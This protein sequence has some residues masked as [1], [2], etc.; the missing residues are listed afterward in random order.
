MRKCPIDVRSIMTDPVTG[1]KL[2]RFPDGRCA[3]T[4]TD[5]SQFVGKIDFKKVRDDGIS[6]VMVRVGG[7]SLIDGRQYE[8]ELFRQNIEAAID[9]GLAV[10]V[11]T[12]T[13]AVDIG[14][15]EK[16]AGY[17][18]SR[19]KDYDITWPVVMDIE[20]PKEEHRNKDLDC[21]ERTEMALRFCNMVENAGYRPM[22]YC[23]S[24]PGM[25][26][27]IEPERLDHVEKWIAQ[28]RYKPYYP[29]DFGIWQ[30]SCEA[31][32][33]GIDE[34]GDLDIAFKDYGAM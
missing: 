21:T 18:L 30:Y 5:V 22:I 3:I 16:D 33:N 6:F 12:C 15:I 2:Y 7:R 24:I 34:M 4:G 31:H 19:I 11:Y 1:R 27:L 14:E 13:F 26:T 20:V 8:D 29:Y 17:I 25:Q 10:G 9:A 23:N 28:Y 32:I